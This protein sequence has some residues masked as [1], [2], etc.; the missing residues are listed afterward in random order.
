MIPPYYL[1]PITRDKLWLP[2]FD[3]YAL[4]IISAACSA[5]QATKSL[6]DVVKQFVISKKFL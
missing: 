3:I 6:I 1:M 4:M 5:K 2:Y